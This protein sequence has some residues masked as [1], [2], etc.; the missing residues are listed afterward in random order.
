MRNEDMLLSLL[1][2]ELIKDLGLSFKCDN[3]RNEVVDSMLNE[4][5]KNEIYETVLDLLERK[6]KEMSV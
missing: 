2:R 1:C 6:Y 4:D 3:D 5:I